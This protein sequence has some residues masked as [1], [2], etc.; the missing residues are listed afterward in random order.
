MAP[1]G[2]TS[3]PSCAPTRLPP[4]MLQDWRPALVIT[5]WSPNESD[6]DELLDGC[7]TELA[8]AACET[9]KPLLASSNAAKTVIAVA[10]VFISMYLR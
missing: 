5:P 3:V 8:V 1:G 9:S 6:C 4:E 10:S 7:W 2:T